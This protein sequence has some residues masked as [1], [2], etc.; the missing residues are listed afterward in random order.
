MEGDLEFRKHFEEG[1]RL[2]HGFQPRPDYGKNNQDMAMWLGWMHERRRDIE[3]ILQQVERELEVPVIYHHV[4]LRE[5]LGQSPK[6]HYLR[7]VY[8]QVNKT[9]EH[10]VKVLDYRHGLHI[11]TGRRK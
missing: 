11:F 3:R 5:W 4:N 8:I 2:Y 1:K 10:R 7:K 6:Q 9:F